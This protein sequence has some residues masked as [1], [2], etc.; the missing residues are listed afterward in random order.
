VIA[1]VSGPNQCHQDYHF[2]TCFGRAFRRSRHVLHYLFEELMELSLNGHPVQMP[3]R[4]RL[5]QKSTK[6]SIIPLS[7]FVLNFHTICF[8]FF[9][10]FTT[11][12]F[13]YLYSAP[14]RRFHPTEGMNVKCV[15]Q[16]DYPFFSL[17][18][19]RECV[20]KELKIS[21]RFV[22][23]I[24]PQITQIITRLAVKDVLHDR[25]YKYAQCFRH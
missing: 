21:P 10:F 25:Y 16:R 14:P 4:L 2:P 12:L 8:S 9:L 5:N 17:T 19:A 6:K 3:M 24:T 18:I 1:L 11:Y 15:R 13:G 7:R 20:Y 22:T 23:L